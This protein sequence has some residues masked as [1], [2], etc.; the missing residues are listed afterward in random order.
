MPCM[1]Q[2]FDV[3]EADPPIGG[4]TDVQDV[5]RWVASQLPR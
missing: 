1:E 4:A 3:Q 2:R 5:M